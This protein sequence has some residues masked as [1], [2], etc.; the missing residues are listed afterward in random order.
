MSQSETSER[1]GALETTL[2][3]NYVDRVACAR[4]LRNGER[5]R[6]A[7]TFK[8]FATLDLFKNI[9]GKVLG[10]IVF[11]TY[12]WKGLLLEL[13]LHRIVVHRKYYKLEDYYQ[14]PY[15]YVRYFISLLRGLLIINKK[16]GQRIC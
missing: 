1:I 6:V 15:T 9:A 4:A 7:R 8:N 11:S 13:D 16:S 3:V 5:A 2:G 12:C 14:K 10:S